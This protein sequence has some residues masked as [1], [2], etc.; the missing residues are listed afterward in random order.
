MRVGAAGGGPVQSRGARYRGE[1]AGGRQRAAGTPLSQQYVTIAGAADTA[2]QLLPLQS[3]RRPAPLKNKIHYTKQLGA[4][5]YG[6]RAS[7]GGGWRRGAG[8]AGTG[9]AFGPHCPY[10][11]AVTAAPLARLRRRACRRLRRVALV[12]PASRRYRFGSRGARRGPSAARLASGPARAAVLGSR[13]AADSRCL[14]A[15]RRD[16]A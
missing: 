4:Q 10:R 15:A 16:V 6:R 9:G 1:S 14:D 3:S 13:R 11:A 2:L 5:L 8:W 7:T 12:P